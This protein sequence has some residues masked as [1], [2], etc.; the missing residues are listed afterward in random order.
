[1]TSIEEDDIHNKIIAE[2]L[3]ICTDGSTEQNIM[4]QTRLPHD[5]LRRIMAEIVD[6]ELLRY[7]E[8]CL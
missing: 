4:K 6:R 3:K 7:I 1:M 2:I 5:S 8:A